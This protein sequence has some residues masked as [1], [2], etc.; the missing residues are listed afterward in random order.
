MSVQNA[1][2]FI[3][4]VE[5]N[6]EFRLKCYESSTIEELMIML[7]ANGIAFSSNDFENAINM[8]LVRCQ[9]YEQADVVKDIENWFKLFTL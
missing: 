2:D 8:K 3:E 4:L 1:N 5:K 6:D 7:N 9:T